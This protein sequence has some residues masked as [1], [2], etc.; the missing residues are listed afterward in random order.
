REARGGADPG[1]DADPGALPPPRGDG[2]AR[3]CPRAGRP[4]GPH[5]RSTE[6]TAREDR[7]RAAYERAG[8]G[9]VFRSVDRLEGD[10]RTRFLDQLEAVDLSLLSRLVG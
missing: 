6:M 10:A 1:A 7:L 4:E 8:Q 9:H 5:R 3:S 2:G